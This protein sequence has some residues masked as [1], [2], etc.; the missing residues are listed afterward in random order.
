MLQK[1]PRRTHRVRNLCQ[2][3]RRLPGD[4]LE[5]WRSKVTCV[6]EQE[7]PRSECLS[8]LETCRVGRV[9]ISVESLPVI[10]PVNF[11]AIE[12]ALIFRCPGTSKLFRGSADSVLAFE[13]DDYD[14]EGAFGW[15]VLVRGHAQ[16]ISGAEELNLARSLGLDA[17]P[18]GELAD[19][20]VVIPL[21]IVTGMRFVRVL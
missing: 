16:E 11:V 9:G 5:R 6:L 2:I 1:C 20:Y 21:T 19:R 13:V 3:G 18:L 8:L 17:W 14:S 7:V 4:E 12:G 15:S 10:V